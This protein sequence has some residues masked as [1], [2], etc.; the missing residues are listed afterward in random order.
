MYGFRTISSSTFVTLDVQSIYIPSSIQ[1]GVA[2]VLD[3]AKL[4]NK[5]TIKFWTRGRDA[6]ILLVF[7]IDFSEIQFIVN[8]NSQSDRRQKVQRV[9]WTC[10]R[11]SYTSYSE[12]SKQTWAYEASILL[13]S[14]C[15]DK[16]SFTHEFEEP[17]GNPIQPSQQRRIQQGQEVFLQ[18]SLLHRSNWSIYKIAI[19][20]FISKFLVTER[21]RMEFW[22][23]PHNFSFL[24]ELSFLASFAVGMFQ[25]VRFYTILNFCHL[26]GPLVFS[27]FLPHNEFWPFW[28][29]PPSPLTFPQ[30]QYRWSMRFFG[31][32]KGG[33]ETTE[34]K[35]KR[36][37]N[38]TVRVFVKMT[39]AEG[40]RRFQKTRLMPV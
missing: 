9:G 10:E 2:K 28:G 22:K 36:E 4:N 12:Q 37:Q 3:T 8:H 14:R 27:M 25:D 18:R 11:R 19:L 6:N 1:E 40:R 5:S 32:R 16:K 17:I 29:P 35:D 26:F 23:W 24:V 13:Q 34:K 21:I 39:P 38:N 31:R 7:T 15:H 20:A 30:S 33:G